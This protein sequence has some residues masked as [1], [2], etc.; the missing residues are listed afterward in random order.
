MS[1]LFDKLSPELRLE[2]YGY[3]LQSD[4]PL[5]RVD[6]TKAAAQPA[7]EQATLLT[8]LLCTCKT[9]Y[10]EGTPVFYKLNTISV[11][12]REVC[13]ASRNASALPP[14]HRKMLHRLIVVDTV[15]DASW[16]DCK[17]C[18]CPTDPAAAFLDLFTPAAF[19]KLRA[20]TV[21]LFGCTNTRC[22]RYNQLLAADLA[23]HYT[24]VGRFAIHRAASASPATVHFEYPWI[25]RPW[26]YYRSLPLDHP[27][28]QR[29]LTTDGRPPCPF[30]NGAGE[31][32]L[33]MMRYLIHHPRG[34]WVVGGTGAAA[35][36]AEPEQDASG[37]GGWEDTTQLCLFAACCARGPFIGA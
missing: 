9:A 22:T 11:T 25:V 32:T 37:L 4:N 26:T 18:T 29:R 12:H 20:L 3:V 30:A 27:D 28:L 24:A 6:R 34:T 33:G 1:P 10:I 19:P 16:T 23:P 17:A 5:K 14:S 36:A 35:G 8:A 7:E 2:I 31:Q 15:P 13:L 21:Q